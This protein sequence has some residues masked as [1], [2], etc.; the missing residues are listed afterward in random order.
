[1]DPTI[2]LDAANHLL[3][4]KLGGEWKVVKRIKRSDRAT[5]GHF[6]VCYHVEAKNGRKAFLKALNLVKSKSAV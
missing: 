6:S 4:P 5:G 2:G 1:M 3:G